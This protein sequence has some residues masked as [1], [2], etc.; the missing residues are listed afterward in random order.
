MS[1]NPITTRKPIA[2]YNEYDVVKVP[3][4]FTDSARTK[5]RPALVLSKAASFNR[6][7]GHSVLAM[8]TSARNAPWPLDAKISDLETA[9]LPAESVVRMK[10]FTLDN[11]FIIEKLGSLSAHDRVDVLN[12][13]RKLLP[14]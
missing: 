7:I 3:F 1:G 8:I 9:G 2:T 11:R 5:K 4:P 13:L 6:E 10:L 14:V 12:G